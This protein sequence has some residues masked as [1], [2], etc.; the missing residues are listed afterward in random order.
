MHASSSSSS[1]SPPGGPD[2]IVDVRD[3]VVHFGD[4]H[5]V[6]GVSLT[7]PRG[8][9]Y[10]LLGPNGAGKTTLIRVLATLLK[11]DAGHVTVAGV[12]VIAEPTRAR[13][14]IGLAGQFAAVDEYQTGRENVQMVG[15]LYGLSAA[16]SRTRTNEVLRRINLLDAADRRVGT[17]SGGMRRRL[18]LA[19][20]LVGRP[21]VMF[22]DE[23]TTGIDPRSRQE[24]WELIQ[25]LVDG[26]TTVL[27]TTQYLEEADRLADRI[28]VINHGRIISEGTADELKDQLG[29]GVVEIGV[30]AEQRDQ[31]LAML[32]DVGDGEATW[33]HERRRVRL[34]ARD[35]SRTLMAVTRALDANGVDPRDLAI[36]RPTLDDVFL[37][38]TGG[39]DLPPSDTEA[40]DAPRGRRG[41]KA[42][43]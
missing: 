30:E 39:S 16:E 36:H 29:T 34:P 22:L 10:G 21:E 17:Y 14:H 8:S 5:A 11:P 13:A 15:R 28:G 3:V 42:R 35:G 26:G 33:D 40:D 43:A 32:A 2:A 38:L 37:A 6:D 19:A 1:S 7:I 25:D 4:V 27:L 12:D 23:P 31:V 18:D 41:R 20:S 9:V 24:L